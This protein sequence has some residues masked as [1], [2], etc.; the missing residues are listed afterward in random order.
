MSSS[1]TVFVENIRCGGCMK[2]I[3]EALMKLPGVSGVEVNKEEEMVR[4]TGND[5]E[6]ESIIGKLASL[7]YPEKG[8]NSLLRKAR[9]L[10]SCATGKLS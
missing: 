2:S 8:N 6:R 4:I 5:L 7:G 10:V 9:S 1:Q 3:R